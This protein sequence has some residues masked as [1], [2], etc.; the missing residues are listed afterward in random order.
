MHAEGR[1]HPPSVQGAG[2]AA[3]KGTRGEE[4]EG[5]EDAAQA[6]GGVVSRRSLAIGIRML[7]PWCPREAASASAVEACCSLSP[8]P[9]GVVAC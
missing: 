8:H 5:R 6:V 2:R 4:R 3:R 9:S 1:R 7:R